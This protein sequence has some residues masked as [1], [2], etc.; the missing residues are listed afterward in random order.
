MSLQ[1]DGLFLMLLSGWAVVSRSHF[2]MRGVTYRSEILSKKQD[3]AIKASVYLAILGSL[4]GVVRR[5]LPELIKRFMPSLLASPK[6]SLFFRALFLWLPFTTWTLSGPLSLKSCTRDDSG[7]DLG[8][9]EWRIWHW[10]VKGLFKKSEIVLSEDWLKLS[11]EEVRKWTEGQQSPFLIPMHP[12]GVLPWGGILNGLTWAG[13]GLQGKT[14]SGSDAVPKP[15]K[16]GA[17]LHQ[18]FFPSMNLRAAVASAVF[19]VPG[20]H[21]MYSR[22][23]CIECTKP[24]MKKLLQK[25]R[26]LAVYPGGAIESRFAKPGRYVCYVK[27]RKGFIRL[28]LEE[29]VPVMPLWTF[30]DEAILP[31][32]SWK[33]DI[34]Y[35]HEALHPIQKWL[36]EATGLLVPPVPGGL[37]QFPPLTTVVSVPMDLSDLFPKPGQHV[38][39]AAVDEAHKRYMEAVKTLFD[40]NKALVPG[41]HENATIEFL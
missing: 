30:G 33:S 7:F 10:M 36:K 11:P 12:H 40:N 29:R 41:G 15:A 25:G 34:E 18:A 32:A 21:E 23:G 16:P 14:S 13:G 3:F 4:D 26:C 27:K 22:L 37:P 2:W 5:V 38:S 31:Q 28:A 19:W 9:L 8:A 39:E 20:F 24:F 6:T 17:G 1:Y 35:G